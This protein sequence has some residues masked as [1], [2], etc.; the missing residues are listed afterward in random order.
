[1]SIIDKHCRKIK[2]NNVTGNAEGVYIVRIR[3]ILFEVVRDFSDK[4]TFNQ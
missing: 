3:P 2:Q 4:M 1:M